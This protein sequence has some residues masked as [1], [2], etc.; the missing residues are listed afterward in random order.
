MRRVGRVARRL[1][2]PALFAAVL[3]AVVMLGIIPTRTYLE[4]RD[5]VAAAE[6][7]LQQLNDSNDKAQRHVDALKSDA[8]I[9]KIAREQYGLVKPGEEAYH[10]LPPP[11]EA[12]EIPDVWPFTRFH[13]TLGK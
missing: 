4:K 3:G 2:W 7:R 1:A 10:V 5:D 11:Q 8:E 13:K 9:E 12:V 6:A